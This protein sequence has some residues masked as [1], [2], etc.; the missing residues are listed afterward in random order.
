MTKRIDTLTALDE[1]AAEKAA[2]EPITNIEVEEAPKVR[3]Y[4]AL[5]W[6]HLRRTQPGLTLDEYMKTHKM[7]D[8]V[9]YVFGEDGETP[10]ETAAVEADPFP[11]S[12]APE[13]AGAPGPVDDAEGPVLSGDGDPAV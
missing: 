2:G 12:G 11:E 1:A 8:A 10:E 13:A 5:A 7:R 4:C 3:I 9:A 6:V